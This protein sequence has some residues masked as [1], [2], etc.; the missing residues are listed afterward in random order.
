MSQLITVIN[1]A[2]GKEE[3]FWQDYFT[4]VAL[5]PSVIAAASFTANINIEAD[6]TF[7]VVKTAYFADITG[8]AQTDSTRVVPLINISISDS[9]SGRNLQNIPVPIDCIAGRGELP[10]VWPVPREF[11]PSSNISVTFQNYSAATTYEN[12]KFCMLGFKRFRY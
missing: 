3:K 12:V 5:C 1:P 8:A 11:K 10:Y 9:G 7:T 2:T 6:S 4:Y